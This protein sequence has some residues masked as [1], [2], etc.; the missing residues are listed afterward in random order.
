[1]GRGATTFPSSRGIMGVMLRL[2]LAPGAL[3]LLAAACSDGSGEPM[4][5]PEPVAAVQFAETVEEAV[6]GGCSTASVKGLTEQIIA[7]TNCIVPGAFTKVEAG[8]ITFEAAATPYMQTAA[9]DALVAALGSKP[10]TAMTVNSM[11]RSVAQQYLLYRWYQAGT[12]GITLANAPGTSPHEVGKG[13]DID[14]YSAWQTALE[15]KG[16]SWQGS[17]DP[18]HYTYVGS[19]LKDLTGKGVLA[20][21]KLWN[22]NHPAD[23]I[24]EDGDYGPQTEARLKQSPAGGFA[25]PPS[26]N[27]NKPPVG[28]LDGADCDRVWGWGQ[29]PDAPT[30]AIAVHLYFGGPAGD[31]NAKGVPLQADQKRDDLCAPLGSCEHGFSV[32]APLS[33]LDGQ[34][35]PVHAYGIDTAGGANGELE[36]SPASLKCSVQLPPGVLRHVTSQTVMGAWKFD[37]FWDVA[38]V[39]DAT[40]SSRKTWDDLSAS[41]ELVQA[42]DGTPEVWLIDETWRRHV[43][44]TAIAAAWELDL[45]AVKKLPA[46]Q[47]YAYE[48]GTALRE[49]P[50]LVKGT[51]PAVY[52]IDDEQGAD[53]DGGTQQPDAQAPVTDAAL[54]HNGGDGNAA[55][56]TAW[57]SGS[58]GGC[59]MRAPGGSW[60]AAAFGALA[61]VLA[62]RRAAYARS[63][64]P[65]ATRP[66]AGTSQ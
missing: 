5:S 66:R 2:R 56:A 11:L 6:Q 28:T 1:M 51:G 34:A 25:T 31:A 45:A 38:P 65:A 36:K 8:N 54:D 3:I 32:A 23:K 37:S 47:V 12:C 9:R 20:F 42:D 16:F 44:G 22:L 39:T 61:L 14:Q 59:A 49:R 18:W 46:A 62:R 29:D 63:L 53:T 27:E 19:G 30:K 52:L 21:Q 7:M 64:T 55:G 15:N 17:G 24:A 58:S 50:F 35:H 57:S 4:E 43:P 33:L 60:I 40:L 13:M 26:C 10:S 41:P 48:K